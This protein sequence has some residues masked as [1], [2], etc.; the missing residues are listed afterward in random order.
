MTITT[1]TARNT[2]AGNGSTLPFNTD[3]QFFD[4]SDLV[5]TLVVDATGAPA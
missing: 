2:F 3:F 4:A 1:V 5:V